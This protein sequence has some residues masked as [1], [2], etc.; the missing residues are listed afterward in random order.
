MGQTCSP[1]EE[2]WHGC[3]FRRMDNGTDVQSVRGRSVG[4]RG[5]RACDGGLGVPDRRSPTG[6]GYGMFFGEEEKATTDILAI[7]EVERRR[8]TILT[9]HALNLFIYIFI[10]PHLTSSRPPYFRSE[11]RSIRPFE[12][13]SLNLAF[14]A[15]DAAE[16]PEAR[17]IFC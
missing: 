6:R 7:Q 13:R 10:V 12:Y 5:S 14:V 16:A 15:S 4:G 3:R 17:R 2:Q 11:T 9:R 8:K 1:Q